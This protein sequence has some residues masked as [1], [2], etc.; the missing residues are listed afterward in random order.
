MV[1]IGR[2]PYSPHAHVGP[3]AGA[4]VCGWGGYKIA[5]SRGAGAQGYGQIREVP[6]GVL[7][8]EVEADSV[9]VRAGES[10]L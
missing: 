2:E 4:C 10:Q 8:S 6:K 5:E 7:G 1:Y 3:V 9:A